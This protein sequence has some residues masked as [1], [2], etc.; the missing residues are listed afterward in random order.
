[1]DSN[2]IASLAKGI[3]CTKVRPNSLVINVP[4]IRNTNVLFEKWSPELLPNYVQN[5]GATPSEHPRIYL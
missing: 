3:S 4:L 5:V 2:D 1:L